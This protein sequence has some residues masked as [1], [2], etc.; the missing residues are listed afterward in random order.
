MIYSRTHKRCVRDEC[1]THLY[2]FPVNGYGFHGKVD[3][4][5][6]AVA[7]N[8]I[9]RFESLHNARFARATI[10]NQH[11]FEEKIECVLAG[12]GQQGVWISSAHS[13]EF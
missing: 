7:L 1:V 8:V 10:A 12:Y 6:I 11:H 3:A 13:Y 9:A 4:N 5:R 2:F